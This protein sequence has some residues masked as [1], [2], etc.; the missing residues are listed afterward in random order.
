M[1]TIKYSIYGKFIHKLKYQ[2]FLLVFF[3]INGMNNDDVYLQEKQELINAIDRLNVLF[4]RQ[5][6]L[7]NKILTEKEIEIIQ[8]KNKLLIDIVELESR[9][10]LL[11]E[12]QDLKCTIN[13]INHRLNQL[14]Q[15][16]IKEPSQEQEILNINKLLTNTRARLDILEKTLLD[17]KLS[18][19]LQEK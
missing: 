2:S 7:E 13:Q 17:N 8:F 1:K 9:L 5:P 12:K 6:K 14:Q 10:Y 3:N 16:V 4:V 19:T 11:E 15:L 18:I